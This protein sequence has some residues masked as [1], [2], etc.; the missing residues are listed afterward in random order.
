DP[1]AREGAGRGRRRRHARC[2]VAEVRADGQTLAGPRG[3][4]APPAAESAEGTVAERALDTR[5]EPRPRM[6]GAALDRVERR[7]GPGAAARLDRRGTGEHAGLPQ[8]PP[9]PGA[10]RPQ[11]GDAGR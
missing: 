4:L 10:Q 11:G 3:A 7:L 8:R 6:V 2:E 1:V 9:G 5:S